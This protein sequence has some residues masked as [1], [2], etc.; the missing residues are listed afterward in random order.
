M[1]R[2]PH[3]RRAAER[4]FTLIET[5]VVLGIAV[6]I[7]MSGWM[8]QLTPIWNNARAES[9]LQTTLGT[10][11]WA[12]EAAIDQ[13]TVINVTF[14][15]PNTLQVYT[16]ACTG[17]TLLST[18]PLPTDMAFQIVSGIPTAN[19][20]DGMG[21]GSNAIDFGY[22]GSSTGGQD[23]LCFQQDGRNFDSSNRVSSGVVYIARQNDL[24]S[25]HA[26]SVLGAT[27]RV[28]GWRLVSVNGTQGWIFE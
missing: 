18:I 23:Y 28:K 2:V 27:G 24:S 16:G 12:R 9:A 3:P 4:G 19:T 10:V 17:G 15:A 21:S 8:F 14:V 11:Q 25:I 26:V 22:P 7:V 6:V 20:P 13:R 5:L 1:P